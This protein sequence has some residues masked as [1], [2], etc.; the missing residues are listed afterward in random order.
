MNYSRPLVR[1]NSLGRLLRNATSL[2]LL[3]AVSALLRA[4][5]GAG[6]VAGSV[7][8]SK[9]HN[10]LQGATVLVPSLNRSLLTDEAGSFL[11]ANL[12]SGPVEIV[13]SYSGFDDERR[14]V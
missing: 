3:V 11:V 9:T 1:P 7:S 4:A 13:I 12:P 14:T 2:L 8:S 10:A 5:D 6:S